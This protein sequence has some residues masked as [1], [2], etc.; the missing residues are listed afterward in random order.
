MKNLLSVALLVIICNFISAQKTVELKYNLEKGKKYRVHTSSVVNQKMTVQGMERST[1]TKSISYMSLKMLDAKP[2]FFMA[3]VK[4]DT[5]KTITSMPPMEISSSNPGDISSE[6]IVEV[7]SCVLNR[8]ANSTM[9]VRMDYKGF[10]LDIVN[11]DVIKQ[12][13]LAGT[14]SL[15]GMADM[16]KGQ[17]EMMA[18]KKTLISMIESVTA[19]LPNKKV[20]PGEEWESAYT[21]SSGFGSM[22]VSGTYELKS[23]TK[24]IAVIEAEN[25]FK[26][27]SSEPLVVNGSEMTSEISGL[28]KTTMEV[29]PSTGWIITSSSKIQMAGDMKVNAQGNLMT[30]PVENVVTNEI[31]ALE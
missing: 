17:I 18:E 13:M 29:D 16:A 22:A 10:V 26:P 21:S 12:T 8:M 15:K 30:I 11:Y 28:G 24:E 14:E 20:A 9:V 5:V 7:M 23:L 31:K 19:Y 4:F 2:E 27:S 25:A 6:A 1:E 3:E